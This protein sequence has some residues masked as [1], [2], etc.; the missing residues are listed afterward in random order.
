MALFIVLAILNCGGYRYGASDQAFYIPAILLAQ[1]PSLFP[2]DRALLGPQARLTLFDDVI[3]YMASGGDELSVLFFAGFLAGLALLLVGVTRLGSLVYASPVTTAA[4][5]IALTLRHR[6]PKTG[7][8]TLEGYLHPRMVAFALGVCAL[9]A[10]LRRHRL[11]AVALLVLAALFHP[12]TAG[13]FVI[14]TATAGV[15]MAERRRRA[16]LGWWLAGAALGA[17]FLLSGPLKDRLEIMDE[18][19]VQALANKDYIF[20]TDWP[21]YVWAIQALMAIVIAAVYGYRRRLGWL[22]PGETG[23]VA[24]CFVLLAAFLCSL[25]LIAIRLALAVQLQTSRVFWMIDLMATVYV[26][27]LISE[28]GSR[29]TQATASRRPRWVFAV[30]VFFSLARGLYVTFVEHGDRRVLQVALPSDEWHDVMAWLARTAGHPHILADPGHA[31]RYGTSVRVAAARD[32]YLEEV[33]D[34]ATALY[35]REVAS[36]VVE[37]VRD[38]GDF[39][40]LS[41]AAV[42]SL[43]EKYDLDYFVTDRALALPA[44]YRNSRFSVYMLT[45]RTRSP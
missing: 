40:H 6:I 28:S 4:L 33:K 36:R 14:W 15:I 22:V 5:G 24:G 23:L 45:P 25:P 39:Q 7:A 44:A 8:N 18:T 41:A 1:D 10:V 29:S 9:T 31:W 3:A 20:P 21:P 2:R 37:R 26:I 32:V 27:W 19:W 13:W 17:G 11:R 42:E 16:W 30:L 34:S 38:A 43:A 35:S 12:T